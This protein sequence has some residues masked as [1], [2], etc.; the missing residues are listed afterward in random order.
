MLQ[1]A[2]RVGFGVS[3]ATL[4]PV[5]GI[6][7][8]SLGGL[9]AEPP[10]PGK[11]AE[12]AALSSDTG[13][14][15]DGN[16]GEEVPGRDV[17]S[18]KQESGNNLRQIGLG[19]VKYMDEHGHFPTAAICDKNDKPLLSWRVAILPFLDA[20]D[21]YKEFRLHE[22]WDSKHNKT[23]LA[24]MPAVYK[25]PGIITR[26]P[27]GTYYQVI[28]G[29]GAMF[30]GLIELHIRDVHDGTANTILAVEAQRPVPWTKPEDLKY[31]A[32]KPLPKLGGVFTDGFTFF[33]V[34][35][36]L[37]FCRNGFDE[38]KMRAAIT[39]AG[40]E[41]IDIDNLQP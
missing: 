2:L 14:Q 33:T 37:H 31:D 27:H 22:P 21:L 23:L 32:D 12:S 4:V 1:N 11:P 18:D 16:D 13:K 29:Q 41:R 8:L 30:D 10:G 38:R 15:D 25:A 36:T 7:L 24:K 19:L 35:G 28:V 39:R 6:T 20:G 40:G 17:A 3:I 5:V 26:K 9:A 34:D